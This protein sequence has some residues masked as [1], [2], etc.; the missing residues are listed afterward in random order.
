MGLGSV[1]PDIEA[2]FRQMLGGVRKGISPEM[3]PDMS[4]Q[5]TA[6]GML[7]AGDFGAGKSHLL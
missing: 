4:I 2:R 5:V 1:Q 6:D 3:A 7:V